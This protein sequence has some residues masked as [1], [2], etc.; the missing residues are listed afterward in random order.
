MNPEKRLA[1]AGSPGYTFNSHNHRV[2]TDWE[3]W[4]AR[5]S[6]KVARFSRSERRQNALG[7]N[8]IRP[9]SMKCRWR[10]VVGQQATLKADQKT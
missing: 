8:W 1:S 3:M 2:R 9:G 7:A 4:V 6:A 5:R 10:A